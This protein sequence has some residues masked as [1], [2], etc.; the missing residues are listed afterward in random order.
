M[1]YTRIESDSGN[2]QSTIKQAHSHRYY[3]QPTCELVFGGEQA[4][5]RERMSN[6]HTVGRAMEA[7]R[8]DQ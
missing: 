3:Q 6:A 5:H 1:F 8:R 4:S 2:P 7:H